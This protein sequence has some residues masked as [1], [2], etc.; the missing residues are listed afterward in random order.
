MVFLSPPPPPPGGFKI[1][2]LDSGGREVKVLTPT[3]TEEADIHVRQPIGRKEEQVKHT[4]RHT[5]RQTDRQTSSEK[6][7]QTSF[8]KTD[9]L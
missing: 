5:D 9:K 1:S 3:E 7:R 4:D 6:V 2:L 8:K